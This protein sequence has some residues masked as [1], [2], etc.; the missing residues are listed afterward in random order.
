MRPWIKTALLAA[1]MLTGTESSAQVLRVNIPMDPPHVSPIPYQENVSFRV[2]SDIYEGFVS[3]TPE[4][5]NVPALAT[6]WAA[7]DGGKHGF[8]FKLRPNVTFHTGRPF[9][10]KEVKATFELVLDPKWKGGNNVQFLQT[11]IGAAEIKAGTR[12]DLPGVR[13]ID[14]LTVEVEFTQPNVVFPYIPIQFFDT[15]PAKEL[16]ADWVD[17]G[18]AGT[19]PFKT[20]SWTR[21]VKVETEAH[22]GYWGGTPKLKGIRFLV[23]PNADTVFNQYDAGELDVVDLQ[24]SMFDKVMRDPRYKAE[25]V[26]GNRAAV[27]WMGMNQNLYAPFKDKRVREAVSLAINRDGIINGMFRGAAFSMPGFVPPGIGGY[28]PNLPKLEY[29]PT[30]AKQLMAEAGFPDGK[31]LPPIAITG[32]PEI[33]DLVTYYAGQ[34]KTVL[35]MPIT[36]DIIERVTWI[37][38]VNAG[39]VAFFPSRWTGSYNDPSVYLDDIWHSKSGVNRAKWKNDAYDALMEKAR[40]TSDAAARLKIFEEAEKIVTSDWAGFSLPVPYTAGLKKPNVK[41]VTTHPVGFLIVRDAQM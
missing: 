27:W 31:G 24:E 41:N 36:P 4:G 14:D 39:E 21:G 33:K 11:V 28:T 20:V 13:V 30:R 26:Q 5:G 37:K 40:A 25:M 1:T 22:A 23:V 10:A 6:S 9:T 19:G 8:R 7:L 38:S 12:S 16:G 2:L 15:T 34:M 35:G 32:W 18:S 3:S 29:N 17:K